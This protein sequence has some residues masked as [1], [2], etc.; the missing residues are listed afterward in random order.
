MDGCRYTKYAQKHGDRLPEDSGDCDIWFLEGKFGIDAKGKIT[1]RE[2]MTNLSSEEVEFRSD[3]IAH[4]E[5]IEAGGYQREMLSSSSP[6]RWP[7]PTL[8][9]YVPIRSLK[10]RDISGNR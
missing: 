6:G 1:P 7:S 8:T 4:I 2:R 10:G 5:H 9:A 3:L